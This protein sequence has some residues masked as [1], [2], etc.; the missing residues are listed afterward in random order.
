VAEIRSWIFLA[1]GLLLSGLTGLA[2][3]GVA[4]ESANRQAAAVGENLAVLVAEADIP[5]RAV[6]A[7][8]QVSIKS[9][10][11]ALVPSGALAS[12]ADAVGQTTIAPIPKGAMLLRTQLVDAGGRRGVSV[13]LEKG[14]VLVAFPTSDP[15]TES[16]VVQ[17][18]DRVDILATVPVAPDGTKR[19]QMIVQN[20]EIVEVVGPTREV[21][22]A[23]SLSFVVDPQT[24]L[25]LKYLRDS[26][27]TIDIAIRS[28]ADGEAAR[29]AS[30]DQNFILDRYGLRR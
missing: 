9:Y 2:L 26:Q 27:A 23:T 16:G 28:R 11:R 21:D 5:A 1:L 7:P 22:R 29:T 30:V 25:V 13:T 3:Y 20:L 8:A 10:P 17:V 18:G 15:L 24:A 12:E 14:K 6:V 19:T 4:Q